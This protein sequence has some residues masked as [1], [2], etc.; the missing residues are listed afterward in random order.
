MYGRL[1][2]SPT[3]HGQDVEN[4]PFDRQLRAM[5][6][7]R[8]ARMA[9]ERPHPL[10]ALMAE[11]VMARLDLVSRSFARALDLGCGPGL[12]SGALRARGLEVVGCDAGA[13]FARRLGTVQAEEDRLPFPPASFDLVV[14]VGTLDSVND[15][16]GALVQVRRLLR[17]DGLF[18]SAF[19]GAGSLPRL[20]RAMAAAD[21][22]GGRPASP[23]I[24]PQIDVR[25]A[26]DLLGRA[27]FALPVADTEGVTLRYPNLA[28]LVTD[29][30]ALGWTNILATRARRPFGRIG[31]AAATAAFAAGADPDGRVPERF[32]II[33]LSG[34][35]PSPDQPRP[36]PRGS[37][38]VSLATALQ[39]RQP[40]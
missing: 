36:A 10:L 1:M 7:D 25:S 5:R 4:M 35:A 22:A 26:G 24:H 16:P 12:L 9:E 33:H 15:L 34:W 17:P 2:T 14:S 21:E 20:K 28:R 8:A 13:I 6:R 31:Y 38:A 11:E 32:E 29:L 27:G 23:H 3:G 30:R 40:G 19:T 18:L 39:R 37:G